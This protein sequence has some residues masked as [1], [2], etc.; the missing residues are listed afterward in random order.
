MFTLFK[1]T[2][3]NY[4]DFW[5]TYESYFSAPDP[6]F[7]RESTFVVLDTETTGFNYKEDRILCIGALILKDDKIKIDETFELYLHQEKFN[8]DTV[9]IHGIIKKDEFKNISEKEAIIQFLTYIKN[10]VLV[11]HHAHFDI[12]MINAMLKRYNLPKL[13]NKVL[14][15]AVLYKATRINSNF[16]DKSK[17]Y[18]LDN[19]ADSL[20]ISKKDRHTAAGDAYITAIAF[21]K[22]IHK[23]TKGSPVKFKDI[24]KIK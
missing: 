15:T 7:L 19:V 2:E 13:K 22:I 20:A 8:P 21:L 24:L 12:N 9:K 18:S 11:A 14:D 3:S 17:A 6:V 1:K 16:I 10:A 4:P 5:K 23:L